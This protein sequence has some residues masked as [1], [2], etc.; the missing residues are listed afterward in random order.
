MYTTFMQSKLRWVGY[1]EITASRRNCSTMNCL[2][3]NA[4]KEAR[5][6]TSKTHWRSPTNISVSPLIAGNIWRRIE[7]SGM[8]LSNEKRTS[9]KP[10][11]MLQL[12]CAGDFEKAQP[13]QPLA[14]RFLVL[15]VQDSS[16]HRLVSLSTCALTEAFLNHKVDQFVLIDYDGWRRRHLYFL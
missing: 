10:E 5:S 16:A 11:K 13:H 4:P 9:M 2:W 1:V 6:S 3:A 15:T 7:R 12:I 14:P 8:K